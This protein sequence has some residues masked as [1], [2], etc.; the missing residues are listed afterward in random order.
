MRET[1][2]GP[3]AARKYRP[4]WRVEGWGLAG[5]PST[6]F[7]KLEEQWDCGEQSGAGAGAGLERS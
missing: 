6:K 3:R 2:A 7:R 4:V 5:S 1:E